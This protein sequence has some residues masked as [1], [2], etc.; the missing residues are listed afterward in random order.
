MSS[1]R[2]FSATVSNASAVSRS[3]QIG[4][5]K[6]LL[7]HWSYAI[8]R[9]SSSVAAYAQMDL[10]GERTPA[11]GGAVGVDHL[12]ERVVRLVDGDQPVGPAGDPAGGLDADRRA[13]Q[14]R[15]ASSGRV[16]SLARSTVTRP[17]WVTSS[18]ASR[19]R[20]IADA[21]TQPGVADRPCAATALP[22]MCSLEASP[23][24]SATHSR[25][26]N[27]VANVAMAWATIAGWYR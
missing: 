16:H 10:A 13:D 27:I 5:G 12:A 2:T 11:A 8:A 18:P 1:G 24:P 9:A 21:L 19:A 3:Q 15:L 25:P 26:S 17:S 4:G 20:M 7:R 23:L 22:V 14:L 6:T